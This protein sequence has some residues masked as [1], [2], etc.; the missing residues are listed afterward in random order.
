[1][2]KS[3]EGVIKVSDRLKLKINLHKKKPYCHLQDRVKDKSLTLSLDS[4]KKVVKHLPKI[5]N[6][7]ESLEDTSDSS[8]SA[9]D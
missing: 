7:M 4:L 8:S 3:K 1:M 6:L 9:S 5:I 2:G